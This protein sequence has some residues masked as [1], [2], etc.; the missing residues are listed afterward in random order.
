MVD[1]VS[2]VFVVWRFWLQTKPDADMKLLESREERAN[3]AIS[4]LFLVISTIIGVQSI[5]QFAFYEVVDETTTLLILSS[6]SIAA[7][8]ICG[9]IKIYISRKLH[10]NALREDGICTS[11]SAVLSIGIVVSS[12]VYAKNPSVWYLDPIVAL[13]VA[14]FLLVWGVK[15]LYTA[16]IMQWWTLAFWKG[17]M[18]RVSL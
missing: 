6:V 18:E 14:V 7:Y 10:S 4:F 2:S 11:A 16:R 8:L 12:A 1:I 5:E 17:E 3:V 15:G 13:L 9:G